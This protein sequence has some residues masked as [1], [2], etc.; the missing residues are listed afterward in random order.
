MKKILYILALSTLALVS[1]NKDLD[2]PPEDQISNDQYWKTASDLDAYII[3]FYA[4]LPS[5][6]SGSGYTGYIGAD[7]FSG[8]D[9]QIQST[10]SPVLNGNRNTV[11]SA[12]GTSW[13]FT[14]IRGVNVFFE[15]YGKVQES[16]ANIQQ[17]VGEA[18]FFKAYYYFRLVNTYGD[19][20]YLSKSLVVGDPELYAPRTPRNVVVDSILYHLDQA[21]AKLK[22][23]KDVTGGN[24]RLSKE[25]ALIFKSRVALF[26]GS[27][28]K[29]HAGTAFAPAVSNPT[30]YF[31]AAVDAVTELMTPSKYKVGIY[32][33]GKPAT[34]YNTLFSSTDLSSNTE[35]IL[36]RK[37]DKNLTFS[38]NF[39]QYVTSSTDDISVT[40]QQVQNYLKLDGT[41]YD[42]MGVGATVK[43]SAYLTKIAAECD[44]RLKQ[45]IWIPGQT[46]WSNTAGTKLFTVP[47]LDKT[48]T[49][50]NATGFQLRKG[51]NPTDPTAGAA[52]GFSTLCETGNPIFRYAEALLNLAEAQAELGLSVNYATTLNV[53]RTRA[54]MPAFTVQADAS[55]SSYADFG[56]SLSNQLYEIRRE[57]AVE[58]GCEGFRTDDWRRWAAGNLFKNKRPLGF[59]FLASEYTA[60]NA[61]KVLLNANGFVDPYKTLLPTGYNF[62]A[63]RDYLSCVPVN[64]ITLNPKLTPNPGW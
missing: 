56:Y 59:P 4:G 22:F 41:P 28:E 57:R 14:A 64:E 45:V 20:P 40:M 42:Y 48:N 54:G 30:K 26:E 18:H 19:V 3:Q 8:S 9:T 10:V 63:S 6:K 38:H 44:P 55:R 16:P 13:D 53:L 50:R 24:N 46:M 21:V 36:W 17:F 27:W 11:N 51:A 52:Q 62:N 47:A 58:L 39:Q 1:C 37:Y 32:N 12:T 7:G 49:D 5:F 34:D 61:A 33:T 25:A 60:A 2:L 29:Y 43:G 31:Q 15:N 35:V 23:L